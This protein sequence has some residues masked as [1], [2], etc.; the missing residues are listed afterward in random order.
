VAAK[1]WFFLLAAFAFALPTCTMVQYPAAAARHAELNLAPRLPHVPDLSAHA[2]ARTADA[3]KIDALAQRGDGWRWID[4][5]LVTT[6]RPDGSH[7]PIVKTAFSKLTVTRVAK[8]RR[9]VVEEVIP[10]HRRDNVPRFP[11][12]R[13]PLPDFATLLYTEVS[14][15]LQDR[16][17]PQGTFEPGQTPGVEPSTLLTTPTETLVL[18]ADGPREHAKGI[19]IWLHSAGGTAYERPLCRRLVKMGWWVLESEFPWPLERSRAYFVDHI[20]GTWLTNTADDLAQEFD[21]RLLIVSDAVNASLKLLEDSRGLSGLPRVVVGASLGGFTAPAVCAGLDRP[22]V[23][24]AF[25]DT[26]ADF[27]DL[28]RHSPLPDARVVLFVLDVQYSQQSNEMKRLQARGLNDAEVAELTRQF[29]AA[30]TLGPAKLLPALAHTPALV[31]SAT[32]DEIV[33]EPSR[34]ALWEKLGRPERWQVNSGHE[35]LVYLL[36]HW[37]DEIAEWI[38]RHGSSQNVAAP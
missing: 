9:G 8:G 6:V 22:P 35:M 30:S 24:T 37:G 20:G 26:G 7:H 27:I 18:W 14:P 28:L 4:G 11:G 36:P 32:D 29:E 1:T 3:S 5:R 34:E 21:Q 33:R 2:L 10:A 17:G 31:V 38:D 23:A 16:F 12:W 25:I 13:G 19:V 15:T